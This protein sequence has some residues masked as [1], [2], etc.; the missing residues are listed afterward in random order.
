MVREGCQKPCEE[1]EKDRAAGGAGKS[2]H[3]SERQHDVRDNTQ[4]TMRAGGRPPGE[5]AAAR[6]GYCRPA[7]LLPAGA[8]RGRPG[9]ALLSTE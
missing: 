9:S 5:A 3:S 1:A 2:H 8:S 4:V 6:R 7:R